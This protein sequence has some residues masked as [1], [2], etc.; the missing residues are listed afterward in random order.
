MNLKITKTNIIAI[1]GVLVLAGVIW[2][3]ATTPDY[4]HL[5][6]QP[7]STEGFASKSNLHDNIGNYGY[8][9]TTN[10]HD[11]GKELFSNTSNKSRHS[12]LSRLGKRKSSSNYQYKNNSS[13]RANKQS[14]DNDKKKDKEQYINVLQ[15]L[16]D[17]DDENDGKY[18]NF[19]DVLDEIDKIDVGA[20]S[21]NSMG[22]TI[23][24]YSKNF[25]KR[26]KYAHK[27]NNKSHID[28][29]M[30]QLGVLADEFHKLFA[31]DKLI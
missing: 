26:M 28:A 12:K 18:D 31:I 13:R 19:Q 30:A 22:N 23:R 3:M 6:V 27:K 20:F 9:N 14:K 24:R 11:S 10:K 1:L 29:S 15:L 25:D 16:S 17:D 5:Y 7:S 4:T 8:I 21:I 2:M